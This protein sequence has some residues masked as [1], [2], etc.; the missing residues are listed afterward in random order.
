MAATFEKNHRIRFNS[1]SYINQEI[2]SLKMY[3]FQKIEEHKC[4]CIWIKTFK[5]FLNIFYSKI[6]VLCETTM[7]LVDTP[8]NLGQIKRRNPSLLTGGFRPFLTACPVRRN[9]KFRFLFIY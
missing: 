1:D 9:F 6:S 4:F 8:L 7:A 2:K 5:F 3:V